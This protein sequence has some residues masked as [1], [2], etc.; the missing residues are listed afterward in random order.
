[1]KNSKF[2]RKVLA[3]VLAVML[4]FAMVPVMPVGADEAEEAVITA[5]TIGTEETEGTVDA[6]NLKLTAEVGINQKLTDIDIV[7]YAT[8]G[9]KITIGNG[10]PVTVE[11]GKAKFTNI[12]IDGSDTTPV[13]VTIDEKAYRLSVEKATAVTDDP[14]IK[15]I[16]LTDTE[17]GVSYEG[18]ITHG[19][20][21]DF[22]DGTNPAT[23]GE[24][25]FYNVPYT[26]MA[27]DIEK[28]SITYKLTLGT[29]IYY[30]D[31]STNNTAF[32]ARG[33]K[34]T[35]KVG[36]DLVLPD[37]HDAAST[38]TNINVLGVDAS[39]AD[40]NAYN[41]YEVSFELSSPQIGNTLQSFK[42]NAG[43]DAKVIVNNPGYYPDYTGIIGTGVKDSNTVNIITV[44]LPFS[45][46]KNYSNAL[47]AAV[48]MDAGARA[49]VLEGASYKE[50]TN[51]GID[52]DG[53][54]LIDMSSFMD[55][56]S[57]GE[58]VVVN[59]RGNYNLGSTVAD[60]VMNGIVPPEDVNRYF[61][62]VKQDKG[63]EEAALKAFSVE[64]NK[65]LADAEV[66]GDLSI[67]LTIP[68]SFAG[69][70]LSTAEKFYPAFS[71][72]EGATISAGTHK[73]LVSSGLK[74]ADGK[75]VDGENNPYLKFVRNSSTGKITT[76]IGYTGSSVADAEVA[77]LVVTAETDTNPNKNDYTLNVTAAAEETGADM[78]ELSLNGFKGVLTEASRTFTVTVPVG[79][80]VTAMTMSYK[81]S[82]MATVIE[83]TSAKEVISGEYVGDFSKTVHFDVKSEDGKTTYKYTVLINESVFADVIVGKWY[84]NDVLEAAALGIVAGEGDNKFNPEGKVTRGQFAA[85]MTRMLDADLSAVG[86]PTFSDVDAGRYYA[87]PIAYMEQKGYISGYAGNVFKP[88]ANITREEMASIL[89]RILNLNVVNHPAPADL[90]ADHDSIGTWARPYVYAVQAD[91]I[92]VG[93]KDGTFQPAGLTTRAEAASV[94]VRCYHKL[95]P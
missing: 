44:T 42:V 50:I 51:T 22:S 79:T 87:K 57:A 54:P 5:F 34:L 8:N 28:W 84:Y 36:A 60:T 10:S 1:M 52:T 80:P 26:T 47:Y 21:G 71:V 43:N 31:S 7:F 58:I 9:A 61:L 65:A 88:D 49:Y 12:D 64:N 27:A 6:Q 41:T 93:N 2:F 63:R 85:M 18:T 66:K 30:V 62:I 33:A 16:I 83:S 69:A 77:K 70:S 40:T 4:V 56:D 73:P 45:T 89:C 48:K 24:I 20:P 13:K 39:G 23:S 86:N 95:K 37:P 74:D 68:Y 46:Y 94:S 91:G 29:S 76:Y 15:E 35:G 19:T 59:Q 25:V 92:M 38:P 75:Q 14:E 11:N 55:I 78:T 72:S 81:V 32:P 3:V 17:N 90:F 67:N 82:K 53:S